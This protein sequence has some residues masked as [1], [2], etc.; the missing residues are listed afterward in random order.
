MI[1]LCW[2]DWNI[3]VQNVRFQEEFRKRKLDPAMICKHDGPEIY[4]RG[5]DPIDEISISSILHIPACGYMEHGVSASEHLNLP[6]WEDITKSSAL[7]LKLP[8]VFLIEPDD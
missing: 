1:R 8:D 3:D 6:L 4:R 2:G 7:R 5:S